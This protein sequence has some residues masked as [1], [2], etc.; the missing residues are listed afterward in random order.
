MPLYMSLYMSLS[1]S[2]SLSVS[3]APALC[4]FA[5]PAPPPQLRFPLL[6]C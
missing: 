6:R 1:L 5:L 3:A 4:V 2:L